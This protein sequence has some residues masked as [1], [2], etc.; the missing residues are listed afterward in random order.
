MI[1]VIG[2]V[3]VLVVGYAAS[4]CFP[5]DEHLKKEWTIWGWLQ[6]RKALR[7]AEAAPAPTGVDTV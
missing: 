1:G 7:A 2:H 6:K 5:T 4:W 3:L